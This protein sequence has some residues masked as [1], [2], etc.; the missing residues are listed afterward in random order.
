MISPRFSGASLA[1]IVSSNAS[2]I[3]FHNFLFCILSEKSP[4]VLST[5]S[6]L[7]RMEIFLCLYI[8]QTLP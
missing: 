8:N 4:L 6:A 2:G 7:L 1:F 5:E 3:C